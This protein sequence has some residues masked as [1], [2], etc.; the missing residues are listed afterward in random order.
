[1][2]F[3]RA[4][5]IYESKGVIDVTYFGTS[6]WIKGLNEEENKAEVEGLSDDYGTRVVKIDDL[7]ED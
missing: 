5:E 2:N 4:K 7:T 6:I 3:K 1:M